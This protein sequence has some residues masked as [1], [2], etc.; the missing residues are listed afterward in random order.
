MSCVP[1]LPRS[2]LGRGERHFWPFWSCSFGAVREASQ[3]SDCIARGGTLIPRAFPHCLGPRSGPYDVGLGLTL[4]SL[5][6][7]GSLCPEA[8]P[9]SQII[10]LG[11]AVKRPT[12]MSGGD[13]LFFPFI[14]VLVGC[15]VRLLLEHRLPLPYTVVLM[16]LGMLFALLHHYQ[17]LGPMSR[18]ISMWVAIKPPD[19]L[20]YVFLPPLLYESSFGSDWF[21]FRR[22]LSSILTLAFLLVFIN[23]LLMGLLMTFIIPADW[24]PGLMLS[25]QLLASFLL[26]TILS[27]TD[28]VAVVALLKEAGAPPQVHLLHTFTPPPPPAPGLLL[29]TRHHWG[30]G[31]GCYTT[32]T[33]HSW[34]PYPRNPHSLKD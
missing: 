29:T 31:G 10:I 7:V 28:P 8:A 27:S 11:E 24:G 21:I 4:S 2:S 33:Y 34:S 23:V 32:Y 15:L 30:W 20:L 22:L 14:A 18:S 9:P 13:A 19:T 12:P 17:D 16:I 1:C 3:T 25:E 26:A 6:I 5:C